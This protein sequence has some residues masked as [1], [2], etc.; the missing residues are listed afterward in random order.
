MKR[1]LLIPEGTKDYL[2]EEAFIQRSIV[3]KLLNL[4]T[5]WGYNEIKTPMLEKWDIVKKNNVYDQK[6]F[7]LL[8]KSGDLLILRPEITAPVAR[9]VATHFRDHVTYPLRLAYAG[10][11][12]SQNSLKS[13]NR[14]QKTQVG[15][16]LIGADSII[17]DCEVIL[18]ALESL[19]S[20]EIKGYSLGIGHM[21]IT[22]GL[23]NE[24]IEDA[25]IREIVLESMIN[26]DIVTIE[27]IL[28][29][30]I[31]EK[32]MI[33]AA[34]NG[35]MEYI[36]LVKNF[37]NDVKFK[38][39][40]NRLEVIYKILEDIGYKDRVF[41]DFGILADFSYY[42]GLLFEGYGNGIGI[43]ILRGGRYDNLIEEYF[44]SKPA[45]GFAIDVDLYMKS[46]NCKIDLPKSEGKIDNSN[47]IER[48]RE[49]RFAHQN[50]SIVE[51]NL[52]DNKSEK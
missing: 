1:K 44:K 15:T 48:F 2:Q 16:E 43:P 52:E 7:S 25:D 47:Y 3:N 26:K 9:V 31:K 51:I 28:P 46:M 38:K 36:E 42:T 6:F 41:F 30:N 22:I 23:L 5:L 20:N 17:S 50:G 21:D 32:V 13:G 14:R 18:M 27:N 40:I 4:F 24:L 35:G 29:E 10:E 8:D 11:V 45:V 34:R 19:E 49:A 39:A 12:F 37:S 33:L